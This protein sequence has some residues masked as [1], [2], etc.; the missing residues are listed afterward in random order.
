MS[1][2]KSFA[3]AVTTSLATLV[4]AIAG[5]TAKAA[6]INWSTAQDITGASDVVTTGTLFAAA[7]FFREGAVNPGAGDV[8]VNG[9]LFTGVSAPGDSPGVTSRTVGNI[10]V[11]GTSNAVLVNMLAEIGLGGPGGY[12]GLL[13]QGFYIYNPGSTQGRTLNFSIGNLIT[14]AQYLIQYWVQ[15]GRSGVS[16]R[17]VIVGGQTLSVNAGSGLGQFITGTFTADGS[18]Q[19]FTAVGGTD[20]VAY[21]NAMQVRLLAVPEPATLAIVGVGIACAVCGGQIR[22]RRRNQQRVSDAA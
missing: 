10:T 8:T 22:R 19:A 18:S 7:N 12:N 14:N 11:T 2:R 9:V 13:N 21:A 6:P 1:C 4:L 15:D 17:T 3:V 16:S 5:Q 20:G